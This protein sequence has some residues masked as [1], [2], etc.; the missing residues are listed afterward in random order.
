MRNRTRSVA[1]TF[2]ALDARSR[3]R[4]R[5]MAFKVFVVVP[6]SMTLSTRQGFP[7]VSTLAFFCFWFAMFAGIAGLARREWL[8]TDRFTAFDEMAVFLAMALLMRLVAAALS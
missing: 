2:D 8:P 4:L 6:A 7:F 5:L 1:R 3:Q